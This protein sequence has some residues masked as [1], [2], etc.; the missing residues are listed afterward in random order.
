MAATLAKPTTT[1][2]SMSRPP[3]P[4]RDLVILSRSEPKRRLGKGTEVC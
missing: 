3:F 4:K 1:A 2:Y